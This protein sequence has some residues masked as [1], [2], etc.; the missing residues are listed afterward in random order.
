M[1]RI[2]FKVNDRVEMKKEHPCGGREWLVMR[3]G[4]DIRIKC[5]KCSRMIMIPRSKF[6]KMVKRVI[7]QEED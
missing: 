6:E 4:M 1:K 2:E 3:T 5:V 7:P